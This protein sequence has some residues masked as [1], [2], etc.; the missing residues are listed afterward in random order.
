MQISILTVKVFN[1]ANKMMINQGE[2]LIRGR[3]A[4]SLNAQLMK[5]ATQAWESPEQLLI[6]WVLI[7]AECGNDLEVQANT[8]LHPPARI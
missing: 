4:F 8:E 2:I 1:W 3:K 5:R 7:Y 6:E